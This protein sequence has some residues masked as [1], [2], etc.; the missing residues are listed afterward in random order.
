MTGIDDNHVP[1]L[2]NYQ[3]AVN[4]NSMNLLAPPAID[5]TWMIARYLLQKAISVFQWTLPKTWNKD[6]FLYVLYCFG[7]LAVVNTNRYGVIPQACG[8]TGYDIFYQPTHALITNPLLTGI[9]QPHI[10]TEC[11]LLKLQPDYGGILDLVYFY[12]NLIAQ[13]AAG[14]G[15][16]LANSKVAYAVFTDKKSIADTIK[17]AYDAVAN[18]QP[19]VVMEKD[20]ANDDGTPAWGTF[21]RDVKSSYIA[22]DLLRDMRK[23]EAMFDN[24]IGIPNANTEKRERMIVDE[25]NANNTE[26]YSK[27]ALWLEQLQESCA[28]ARA[29]F[30]IELSVKWREIP[31]ENGGV[32]NDVETQPV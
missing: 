16:N 11:T 10:G 8:L 20:L 13:T 17:K 3:L 32:T 14:I 12:A 31:V 23:L 2:Q 28:A 1:A 30:D 18:G 24:D 9:L 26:T 4:C 21:T 5:T 19:L 27:C 15:I 6:Y 7:H 25:V 22:G 29:M